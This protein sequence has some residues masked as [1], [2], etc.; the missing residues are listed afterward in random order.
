MV[1]NQLYGSLR[2][3]P[4]KYIRGNALFIYYRQNGF[5][6]KIK[7]AYLKKHP[8][9][10]KT[11]QEELERKYNFI[12]KYDNFKDFN[13]KYNKARKQSLK[14]SNK[15]IKDSAFLKYRDKTKPKK[16]KF[17][18]TIVKKSPLY[19]KYVHQEVEKFKKDLLKKTF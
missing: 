19:S 10:A 14:Y 11:V 4:E 3:L 1:I 5:S 6:P 13:E 16:F 9:R 18:L 8:Q 2:K 17:P 7:K 15:I 12:K